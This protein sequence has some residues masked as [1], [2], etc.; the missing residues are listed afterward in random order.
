MNSLFELLREILP[1]DIVMLESYKDGTLGSPR[2]R[3][4]LIL[5][6]LGTLHN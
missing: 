6:H 5:L 2:E 4:V 1:K 3:V